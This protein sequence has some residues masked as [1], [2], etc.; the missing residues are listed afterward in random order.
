MKQKP[1]LYMAMEAVNHDDEL[2]KSEKN[3]LRCMLKYASLKTGE[4]WPSIATL[5]ADLGMSERGVQK[6]IAR[7]VEKRRL[8][9]LFQ[10]KGGIAKSSGQGIPN[11][12]RLN[13]RP[14]PGKRKSRTPNASAENPEP[15]RSNPELIDGQPRTVFGQTTMNHPREEAREH[16][17][18]YGSLSQMG[19]GKAGKLEGLHNG[20]QALRSALSACGVKGTNLDLLAGSRLTADDVRREW[21]TIEYQQGIQN[22]PAML[23]HRLKAK[24][25]LSSDARNTVGG[26][27]A[28]DVLNAFK[29]RMHE[30]ERE[31]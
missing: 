30:E 31:I 4:C 6:I 20:Q 13:L 19:N 28:R 16:P 15:Q 23:V 7:L 17:C 9:I 3:V 18:G 21:R 11:R 22:K 2:D 1:T 24:C 29:M 10:S 25:G 27:I 26:A 5:A 14:S 8:I 12:W